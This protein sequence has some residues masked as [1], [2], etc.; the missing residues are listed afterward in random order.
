MYVGGLGPVWGGPGDVGSSDL[1]VHRQV[2]LGTPP[3]SSQQAAP[4]GITPP[5]PEGSC[6]SPLVLALSCGSL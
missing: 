4:T 3:H 5:S 2:L 1:P 6:E